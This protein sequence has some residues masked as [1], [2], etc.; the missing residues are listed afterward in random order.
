MSATD[1]ALERCEILL[2]EKTK[3]VIEL[4]RKLEACEF[5]NAKLRIEN[6]KHTREN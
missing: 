6:E 5:E 2:G 1:R 3:E 4:R